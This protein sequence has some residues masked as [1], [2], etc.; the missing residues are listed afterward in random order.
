MNSDR[1]LLKPTGAASSFSL[2]PQRSAANRPLL[3]RHR[4]GLPGLRQGRPAAAAAPLR[5]ALL[6]RLGLLPACLLV[7]VQGRAFAPGKLTGGFF[8][9]AWCLRLFPNWWA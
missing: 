3:R 7:S 6:H 9:R 1:D 4:P 8:S 5:A 2:P